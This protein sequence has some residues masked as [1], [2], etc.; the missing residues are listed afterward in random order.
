VDPLDTTNIPDMGTSD[1]SAYQAGLE[2][3]DLANIP[4]DAPE[5]VQEEQEEVADGNETPEVA[6]EV[7][8]EESL[9]EDAPEEEEAPASNRFRIRAK[10]AVE[11]E[12]LALRKRH[13]D[14]SLKECLAK[15]EVILGVEVASEDS[16]EVDPEV[17][18]VASVIA[19][20]DELRKLRASATAEMDFDTVTALTDKIDDLRDKRDEL[21]VSEAQ[22]KAVAE[23]KSQ[24]SFEAEYAKSE[25]MTVSHYPDS[26]N[27]ESPM[28]KRM[29]ELDTQMRDLGDPLYHSPEKP[30][31]LAKAVARELG[32]IMTKP[33]SAPEKPSRSPQV[34]MQPAPG[35][36][37]TT[38]ISSNQKLEEEIASIDT[39][40]AYERRFGRG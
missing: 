9:E 39:L 34:S 12:A 30:W 1:L 33:G 21:K 8:N 18:T 15:A 16:Q 27:P 24:Q 26:T 25:K 22:V 35:N 19:E 36:R 23:T 40:D 29:V 14:L 37:G 13:P 10:D 11:A 38:P 7:A 2:S 17:K 32:I 6:E 4:G 28:V 31:I 3:L 20:I 5:E